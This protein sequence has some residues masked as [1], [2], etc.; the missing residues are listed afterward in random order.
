M[1]QKQRTV[2]FLTNNY[3]LFSSFTPEM[4]ERIGVALR[5]FETKAG[6]QLTLRSSGGNDSLF[7]TRGSAIFSNDSVNKECRSS[8][9]DVQPVLFNDVIDIITDT[10]AVICHIDGNLMSDYRLLQKISDT[11]GNDMAFMGRLMF[12][13][14][15]Q[16]FRLLPVETVE[17]AAKRCEEIEVSN[18]D[19][20]IKQD[21]KADGF[22]ILL[23]GEAEVWREELEDDEPQMVASLGV[24]A[25]FGE[26]ALIIG[27]ARNATITMTSDGKLL[28][29]S[30]EDFDDLI[31]S[32]AIRSVTPQVALAMLSE[33][34]EIIDVRYEDEYE[35]HALPDTTLIPLPVLRDHISDLDKDKAYLILCAGGYRAAAA[36]LLLRQQHINA[37]FIEGGIKAWPE[38]V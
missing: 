18:G 14:S 8:Q 30:K 31:S 16:A 21:S 27:G 25:T 7:V 33:G 4:F 12:L 34:A 13:K 24:G 5:T 28:K 19:I 32:N 37:T 11:S 2:S 3:S 38:G 20:I 6:E 35:M 36:T 15:T 1:S 17:E 10:E 23:D 22:Y 9:T 29:L 26:E